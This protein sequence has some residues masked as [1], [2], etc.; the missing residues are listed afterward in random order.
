MLFPM[1]GTVSKLLDFDNVLT[2]KFVSTTYLKDFGIDL[3]Q[4]QK[5]IISTQQKNT[6]LI[7]GQSKAYVDLLLKSLEPQ[8]PINAAGIDVD[9]L[10]C[11]A[12]QGVPGLDGLETELDVVESQ[13]QSPRSETTLTDL[14]TESELPT[15]DEVLRVLEESQ[16]SSNEVFT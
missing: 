8:P 13:E 1:S 5:S 7:G 4:A 10:G 3:Q 2:L 14:P 9:P 12:G 6:H 11:G 16:L 15:T